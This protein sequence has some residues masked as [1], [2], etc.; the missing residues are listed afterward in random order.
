M[1]NILALG[2]LVA[3]ALFFAT[4]ASARKAPVPKAK[5]G[6]KPARNYYA[7]AVGTK[8]VYEDGGKERTW[9]VTA[10]AKKKNGE[11]VVIVTESGPNGPVA[12]EKV[13][14]SQKGLFKVETGRFTHAPVCLLELPAKA[15]NKWN[16]DVAQQDMG[17]QPGL[18][19]EKGTVTVGEVEEVKVPAGT[20]EALRVEVVLTEV[21]GQG[22][23]R[24]VEYTRW[25]DPE[26]G[27]VKMTQGKWTREL[28][29]YTPGKK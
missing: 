10:V 19:G 25:Y 15:G 28:K 8:W 21:N 5:E 22:L 3:L 18:R 24:Q 20:F 1:R 29:S 7:S 9:E 12:V 14:V 2:G 6:P 17:Q 4:S 27:L 11:T 26:I 23:V 16:F 13:V